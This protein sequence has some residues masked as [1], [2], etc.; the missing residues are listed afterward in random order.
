MTF[1]RQ[2][3]GVFEAAIDLFSGVDPVLCGDFIGS[4][5]LHAAADTGVD[6]A[7]IFTDDDVVNIFRAF[8]GERGF[9]ARIKFDRAEADVLVEF[10]A[11]TEQDAFF[12]N[13]GFDLGAADGTEEGGIGF[14]ELVGGIIGEDLTGGEIVFCAPV[15]E[16]LVEFKAEFFTGGIDD[17][18]RFCDDFRTG[19]VAGDDCDLIL[20]HEIHLLKKFQ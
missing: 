15:V 9:H 4:T 2:F 16:G 8:A 11:Q 10:K 7:G 19:T 6:A 17:F 14:A 3:K 12:Q 20:I 5:L 18:Q 1:D 13:S